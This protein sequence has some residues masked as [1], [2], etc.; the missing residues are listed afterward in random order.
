[1]IEKIKE[2]SKLLSIANSKNNKFWFQHILPSKASMPYYEK[3]DL[4]LDEAIE[5]HGETAHFYRMKSDLKLYTMD[6]REAIEL[7]EVAIRLENKQKDKDR[8]IELMEHKDVKKPV[9]KIK[10]TQT[11]IKEREIPYFKYHPNPVETGAFLSDEPVE[12]DCCGKETPIYYTEPFYSV[13]DIEALCP[14]CIASGK[15]AK[16]FKGEFQDYT[17]IEGVAVVPDSTPTK[18]YAKEAI[19]ELTERTPGYRGWQQEIWLGHCD[20]LCAFVGYVG[21]QEI[22]DKL[23]QF[24]DL[25]ADCSDFGLKRE[26]LPKCLRDNGSCQGYLFQ[27]LH[28]GKY[29]LYFDFD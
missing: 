15:A 13:E 23:D 22:E 20:D 24:V 9:Q 14:W 5:K 27:C 18:Q 19:T 10:S 17:S 8:L 11:K 28:C 1:M 26:D 21:W 25:D 29:R 12:C 7:L 16:K 6:Y 2:I 3:A 4:L